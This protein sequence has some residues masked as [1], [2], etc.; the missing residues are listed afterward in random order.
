MTGV[1]LHH[2][3]GDVV[4]GVHRWWRVTAVFSTLTAGAVNERAKKLR[5]FPILL[6]IR[7]VL[8]LSDSKVGNTGTPVFTASRLVRALRSFILLYMCVII[9]MN[10][11]MLRGVFGMV[12]FTGVFSLTAT[13]VT[14][15]KTA[16]IAV[17]IRVIV[18][19][20][21]RSSAPG[22]VD[23]SIKRE[24]LLPA[25]DRDPGPAVLRHAGTV[26]ADRRALLQEAR[27]GCPAAG[28]A[29]EEAPRLVVGEAESARET[30]DGE[31]L[32]PHARDR[33]KRR[34][35]VLREFG[36]LAAGR[37][38]EGAKQRCRRRKVLRPGDDPTI[39]PAVPL[40]VKEPGMAPD[41]VKERAGVPAVL[42]C[43]EPYPPGKVDPDREDFRL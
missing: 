5:G 19:P 37:A 22:P 33:F 25:A 9:E 40:E 4:T 11:L 26:E 36:L 7:D 38:G 1:I 13:A 20:D 29:V 39:L 3:Q 16:V 43:G 6:V 27:V 32:D 8:I 24:E 15:L 12:A 10:I 2:R 17:N 23:L 35:L 28:V 41:Q 21:K 30:P 31:D 34:R 18:Q 14:L 42:G